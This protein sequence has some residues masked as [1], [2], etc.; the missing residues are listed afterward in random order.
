MGR[1]VNQRSRF[2]RNRTAS[3]FPFPL[4]VS[5]IV[6]A[7]PLPYRFD[8]LWKTFGI[9]IAIIIARA[10][11]M[12][13]LRTRVA[14]SMPSD[15][16]TRYAH[17]KH[18]TKREKRL[19]FPSWT[20]WASARDLKFLFCQVLSS[21]RGKY[22]QEYVRNPQTASPALRR[23]QNKCQIA[24]AGSFSIP[25]HAALTIML[26]QKIRLATR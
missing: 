6:A 25:D 4:F 13:T 5:F 22:H 19:I 2:Q 7:N 23:A 16:G 1:T 26:M 18:C 12:C 11:L 15:Y 8:G 20:E 3:T 17:C 10:I 21:K 24:L 9:N 14:I